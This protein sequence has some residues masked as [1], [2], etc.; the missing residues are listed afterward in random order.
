MNE[1]HHHGHSHT[2]GSYEESKALL[3]YMAEH[4][5]HHID[6]LTELSG[7]FPESVQRKIEA[8]AKLFTEGT[9]LLS[10]AYLEIGSGEE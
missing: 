3:K 1:H 10:K 6:E 2:G 4:N 8:A 5:R 7:A 9:D